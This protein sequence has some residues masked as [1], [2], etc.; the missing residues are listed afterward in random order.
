MFFCINK[1]KIV[2]KSLLDSSPFYI[3]SVPGTFQSSH[4]KTP[5]QGS[6]MV[7]LWAIVLW[8]SI[9]DD[10]FKMYYQLQDFQ[11]EGITHSQITRIINDIQ[12]YDNLID[13]W[14]VEFILS[15]FFDVEDQW[16]CFISDSESVIS[17]LPRNTIEE[18]VVSNFL[19][20]FLT[21][22]NIPFNGTNDSL[23][24]VI[25]NSKCL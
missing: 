22:N 23:E 17:L 10:K 6:L 2:D 4:M 24:L 5:Q 1:R 13:E 8:K 3:L 16:F 9:T 18:M 15:P 14:V 25:I 12:T 11:T 20:K 21:E 19:Y 7:S